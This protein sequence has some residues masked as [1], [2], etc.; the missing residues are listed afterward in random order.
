MEGGAA[1]VIPG[2]SRSMPRVA[3]PTASLTMHWCVASRLAQGVC[4][5]S[6]WTLREIASPRS[7]RSQS[8]GHV[9]ATED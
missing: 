5:C 4:L 2:V 8:S 3:R 9:S 1:F 6:L 7:A